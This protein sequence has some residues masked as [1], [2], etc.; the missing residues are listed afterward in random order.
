MLW[1]SGEANNEIHWS[2]EEKDEKEIDELNSSPNTNIYLGT[3]DLNH[4]VSVCIRGKS[5]AGK[6]N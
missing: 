4:T 3:S 6:Y 1:S 2:E 5:G